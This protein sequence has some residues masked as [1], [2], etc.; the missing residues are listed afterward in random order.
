MH[1]VLVGMSHKTAPV[2]IRE[3]LALNEAGVT[4]ALREL[5]DSTVIEEIVV[6]STCNRTEFYVLTNCPVHA[7][8]ALGEFIKDHV[9]CGKD[10][11][12]FLYRMCDQAVCQ[13]LFEVAASL[14]SQIVGESQILGQVKRALQLAEEQGAAR[15]GLKM[16][17]E[18]ALLVAQAVRAQ[19][20]VGQGSV[21][22]G[23]VGVRLAKKILGDLTD[24][25]VL[26]LGAGEVGK[27]VVKYLNGEKVGRTWIVN[28]TFERA[29]MLQEQ[30]LGEAR[31]LEDLKTLIQETDVLIAA[32]D[33]KLKDLSC[34]DLD[35]LASN[36]KARSLLVIDLGVPR[37]FVEK[38]KNAH[39]HILTLDDLQAM[40]DQNRSARVQSIAL[41][42][43]LIDR[44]VSVFYG[45][46]AHAAMQTKTELFDPAGFISVSKQ[47][48]AFA[49]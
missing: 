13:H 11:T 22:I 39:L 30:G 24:K 9:R 18:K 23:S 47:K 3:L 33:G 34:H 16:L 12:S 37:T 32:I 25:S 21:S 42:K 48:S 44:D 49:L 26:L 45:K 5:K 29:L 10:L 7:E 35:E 4:K 38:K 6:L 17:F 15:E 27:L 31:P 36:R 19:S 20:G 28:R 1:V 43:N 14:D 41:A 40:A 46:Q 2:G 8:R